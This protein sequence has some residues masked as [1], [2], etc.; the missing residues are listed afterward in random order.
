M[1]R[2]A[3]AALDS[4][5]TRM[6][7]LS[8]AAAIAAIFAS[9]SGGSSYPWQGT[10]L[11]AC[12]VVLE[13]VAIARVLHPREPRGLGRRALFSAV[14]AMTALWFSAQDTLGAPAYVFMHQ[15]WLVWI[16]VASTAIALYRGLARLRRQHAV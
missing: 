11:C 5:I 10:T 14:L 16:I 15:R 8:A 4:M 9:A 7:A 6:V 1:S 3:T 12:A 13:A 2:H